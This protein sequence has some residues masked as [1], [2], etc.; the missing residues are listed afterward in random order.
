MNHRTSE[1]LSSQLVRLTITMLITGASTAHVIAADAT[2]PVQ[3]DKVSRGKYLVTIAGCNDCRTPWMVGPSGTA[4][5]MT[6]MLSDLPE[7]L[8]MRP[9]SQ[10]PPGPWLVAAAGT[11]AAWAG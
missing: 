7:R 1:T 8:V 10:L 6:R 4:P 11:N 9:A 5:D 2:K 3:T